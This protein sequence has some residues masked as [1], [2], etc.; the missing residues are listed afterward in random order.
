MKDVHVVEHLSNSVYIHII[1]QPSKCTLLCIHVLLLSICAL[2]WIFWSPYALRI[3]VKSSPS[4]YGPLPSIFKRKTVNAHI[5]FFLAFC[6]HVFSHIF[7]DAPNEWP[8]YQSKFSIFR[9][10]GHPSSVFP[11]FDGEPRIFSIHFVRNKQRSKKKLRCENSCIIHPIIC[12]RIK[13]HTFIFNNQRRMMMCNV[14]V[15]MKVARLSNEFENII[16]FGCRN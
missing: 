5:F 14:Y 11:F 10:T 12:T 7:S 2:A 4:I 6:W 13:F 15:C 8:R 1:Y 16:R 9:D 3:P